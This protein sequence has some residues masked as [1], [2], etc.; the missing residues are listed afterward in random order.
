M[1]ERAERQ[2]ALLRRADLV[3]LGAHR[4]QVARWVATARLHPVHP[5]V[6]AV[7]HRILP[8]RTQLLAATW[9]CGGDAAV[10]DE[11][12]CA[13]HG[14]ITESHDPAP[15]VHITT[16]LDRHSIPGVVVHRTRRLSREDVLTFER[17]LRVTDEARTLVDRAD[18]LDFWALRALAD[19]PRRLDLA[20]V[21]R[22]HR[23]LPGRRGAGRIELLLRSE[24][25][26]ARSELE[27]R[28][29]PYLRHHGVQQPDDR[30]VMV[31]GCQVDCVWSTPRIALELD[32]RAHHQ[33][34]AE[35]L[36]DKRRD[37]RYRRAGYTPIRVMW[38]E[39]SLEEPA[40]AVELRE[41][42]G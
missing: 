29:T 31:A 22:A 32:S 7:G 17:L 34:R 30:N 4:N 37:R 8:W 15:P 36:E 10:A 1:L 21:E 19:A 41:L 33:R 6:W 18:H 11:S 38:E 39:L 24:D 16:T 25:A 26:R 5:G 27:R 3:E 35:Q 20:R 13:F 42:L 12:A 2:W 23:R 14:W 9:W 40:V 28:L